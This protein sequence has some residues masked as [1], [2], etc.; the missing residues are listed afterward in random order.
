LNFSLLK[1]VHNNFIV[2]LMALPNLAISTGIVSLLSIFW[3]WSFVL[4]PTVYYLIAQVFSVQ[5]SAIFGQVTEMNFKV[6]G[7]HYHYSKVPLQPYMRSEA[8]PD[9]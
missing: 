3:H 2:I 8:Q 5:Y 4:A 6:F 7:R 9:R 1:H